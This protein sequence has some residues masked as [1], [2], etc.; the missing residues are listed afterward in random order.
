MLVF[1]TDP[2][3]IQEMPAFWLDNRNLE[4]LSCDPLWSSH[5]AEL[6]YSTSSHFLFKLKILQKLTIT[7]ET[8]I[9]PTKLKD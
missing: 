4:G 9:N 2:T 7:T 1:Q 6:N 8:I 3:V 5:V